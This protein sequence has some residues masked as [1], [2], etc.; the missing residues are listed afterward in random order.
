MAFAVSLTG[1]L[2]FS[3]FAAVRLSVDRA[4]PKN[5]ALLMSVLVPKGT[6]AAVLAGL[7][8]QLGIAGGDLM[9]NLSYGVVTFS[10]LFTAALVFLMERT[11]LDQSPTWLFSGFGDPGKEA[12][13]PPPDKS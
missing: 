11:N 1:I 8:L 13:S 3:R 12:P 7:P 2:L 6:A 5:E 9:Q 4:T 10:I